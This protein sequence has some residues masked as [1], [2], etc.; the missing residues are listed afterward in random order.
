MM[1]RMADVADIDLF[2]GLYMENPGFNGGIVGRTF[3]C[4]IGDQ[5]ARLKKGDRFFYDLA[6]QPG[7]FTSRQLDAIRET[8]LA[9]ILCDNSDNIREMQPLALQLVNSHV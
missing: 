7:S 5:F 6:N 4:L 2:T 8:S 1:G 9:R 3:L